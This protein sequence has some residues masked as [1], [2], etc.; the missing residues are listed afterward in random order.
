MTSAA[1]PK[2]R[3]PFTTL[4]TRLMLTS[5]STNSV[6]SR[7]RGGPSPSRRRRSRPPPWVRAIRT[8]SEF[9]AALA[10]GFGQGLDPAMIEIGAAVED[11]LLNPGR[12][13]AL[14]DQLADCGG[15]CPVA[16]ALDVRLHPGVERRGRGQGPPGGIVDDLGIDVPRRAKHR[17]PQAALG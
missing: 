10:G 2:R 1:K 6:S 5:F 3:P 8:S 17:E 13:G 12:L 15:C 16:A 14:G 4:A 9:E 11:D 7:S